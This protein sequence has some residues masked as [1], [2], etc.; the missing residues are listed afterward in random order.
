MYGSAAS[1]Y[2]MSTQSHS[3][4]PKMEC[5]LVC[6][7]SSNR[8]IGRARRHTYN[9][10]VHSSLAAAAVR[11]GTPPTE[12]W[13]AFFLKKKSTM[14]VDASPPSPMTDGYE[15]IVVGKQRPDVSVLRHAVDRP[16]DDVCGETLC[17]SRNYRPTFGPAGLDLSTWC[18]H[19][20]SA[21]ALVR[22]GLPE[23]ERPVLPPFSFAC[24]A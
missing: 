2:T 16:S 23:P 19:P 14:A 11:P 4:M 15:P 1:T 20:N 9:N 24:F 3:R 6:G 12:L 8:D 17:D 13:H 22:L 10:R 7:R 21:I 18:R 5:R